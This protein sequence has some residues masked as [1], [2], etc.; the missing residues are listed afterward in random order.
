MS[1]ENVEIVRRVWER[2]NAG[3]R[4]ID[5]EV[6]HPDLVIHSAM[7]KSVYRG[8]EGL[9]RWQAEIDDQ[10]E[11]WRLSIDQ[12]REASDGR[13]LVLGA[14]HFRGRTSGVEFDQ[15]MGWLVTFAGGQVIEFRN[16]ADQAEALEAAGLS[17]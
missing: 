16:I 9:R 3:E 4:K 1:Q 17:E 13:L 2:W 8:Y 11:N 6:T 15:P 5:S 7:T 10:F 12:F 14:V